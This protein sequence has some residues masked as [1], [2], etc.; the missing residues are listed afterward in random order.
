MLKTF[1]TKN[2]KTKN[3]N[4][5][6]LLVYFLLQNGFISVHIGTNI[7][8]LEIIENNKKAA[9]YSNLF[10]LFVISCHKTICILCLLFP[11][12]GDWLFLLK[13]SFVDILQKYYIRITIINVHECYLDNRCTITKYCFNLI[14]LV[15]NCW[16]IT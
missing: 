10:I 14:L 9:L 11:N 3:F 8:T 15:L 7:N 4:N 13:I 12:F 1:K 2:I 16:V 6:N 5:S